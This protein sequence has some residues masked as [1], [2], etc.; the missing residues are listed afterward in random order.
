MII[1]AKDNEIDIS[2]KEE[3]GSRGKELI[4]YVR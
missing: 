2:R 1:T 4:I 3:V